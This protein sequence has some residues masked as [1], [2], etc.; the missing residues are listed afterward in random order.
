MNVNYVCYDNKF[1]LEDEPIFKLNRAMKF[2]DGVFETIRIVSGKPKYLDLHLERMQNGLKTLQINCSKGDVELLKVCIEQLIIKN[3]IDHGGVLRIIAQ[4][5]GLGKY[6]PEL[7]QVFF[8]S[9]TE[10]VKDEVYKLN[11]KGLKLGVSE[12]TMIFANQFSNLKTLNAIP[13][14]LAA[15]EKVESNF[16]ELL[17]LN[18]NNKL[19]E[20]TSSN[21]FFVLKDRVVTPSLKTG[22]VAGVMRSIVIDELNEMGLKV[23]EEEFGL[24][25][26]NEATEI[27]TTNAIS[28]LQWV[29]SYQSKRYFKRK[30]LD[31]I[32][33][34]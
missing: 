27:F 30:V 13:Y 9:E 2:G 6:A 11:T 17:L 28:G 3:E 34:I 24:E 29:S 19:V 12:Q 16:D 26:L 22:C 31:L 8:Y 1:Y 18:S 5:S 4:R 21:V 20:A 7:N 25:V 15:K 10:R 33:R 32:K 14:V 23:S